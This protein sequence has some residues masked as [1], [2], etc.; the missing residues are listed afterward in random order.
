MGGEGVPEQVRVHVLRQALAPRPVRRRAAAPR[1]AEAPRRCGRRTALLIGLAP[2]PRARRASSSALIALRPDR[3][4]CAPCCPCRAR[5]PAVRQVQDREVEADELRQPQA[6]GI[7][8]LHDGQVAGGERVPGRDRQQ[9][10]H[11]IDIER[12]RQAPRRLGRPHVEAR[13]AADPRD[14]AL[15][16]TAASQRMRLALQEPEEA[17]HR[18]QP[19]LDAA[20]RGRGMAARREGRAR[21]VSSGAPARRGP[22]ASQYVTSACRSRGRPRPC[23]ASSVAPPRDSAGSARARRAWPDVNSRAGRRGSPHR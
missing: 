10:R 16:V 13:I 14:L 7:E 3:A 9:A 22:C 15:A 17:A 12:L 2:A 8:Q 19:P 23:A 11:L 4:R 20:A 1:A 21:A 18:R 6:R 5:A